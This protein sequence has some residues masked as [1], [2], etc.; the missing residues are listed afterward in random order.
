MSENIFDK[1]LSPEELRILT[2]AGLAATIAYVS[3][4]YYHRWLIQNGTIP[5]EVS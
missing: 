1:K 5:P 3:Y 2:H 4:I